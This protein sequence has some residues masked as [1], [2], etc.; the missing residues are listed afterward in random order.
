VPHSV[1]MEW[2]GED[3]GESLLGRILRESGGRAAAELRWEGEAP[4]RCVFTP[5]PGAAGALAASCEG[6]EL[7][8]REEP[9]VSGA[10]LFLTAR[11]RRAGRLERFSVF[12]EIPA[13]RLP[14]FRLHPL[15][16]RVGLDGRDRTLDTGSAPPCEEFA[17]GWILEDG[18][19]G[20]LVMRLPDGSH[21]T[22]FV[23]A[24]IAAGD[25]E[26]V[27]RPGIAGTD[28]SDHRTRSL[29]VRRLEEGA[30]VRFPALRVVP[31]QGG[32]EEG[33]ALFRGTLQ[34]SLARLKEPRRA[35]P[36]SY[37]T[38]HDFGP[39]LSRA[40]LE[41]LL[42][43]LREM[44]FGLLHLDPGWETFWGS[45]VWNR[46]EM[47]PVEEFV[48]LA[49]LHGLKVGC[50]TTLHTRSPEVEGAWY[51]RDALGRKFVAED[52]GEVKLW[53]VCPSGPWRREFVRNMRTLADAGIVFINSDFH[54]WPWQGQ[55]CHDTAHGHGVP[56]T[57]EEWALAV[58]R[59]FEEIRAGHP[60]LVIEMHD[61]V[62]SGEY[63]T[64]AWYL[65]ERPESY[66][67][68][69]AYEFMWK[70]HRD[71]MEGRLFSLYHLRK[72]EPVPL[73]LHMNMS[74]DN[75]NALAF[76]YVASCVTHVGV[77]GVL[78]APEEVREG[79]RRAIATYN[80]FFDEFTRGEFIGIDEL[81]HLHIHPDGGRGVLVC[82][83]LSRE[84][85]RRTVPLP[86]PAGTGRVSLEG[87][88]TLEID[89]GAARVDVETGPEDVT[90]RGVVFG[91]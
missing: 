29:F 19:R 40:K 53:G 47:G 58:N 62:E 11:S 26:R 76:W 54:D 81:T 55:S 61:H 72:A 74:T 52:F 18:R 2:Q 24:E 39:S 84:T 6:L 5:G 4:Q 67:E 8:L 33:V 1:L 43:L 21:E 16:F 90:V 3:G 45:S 17:E 78:K 14:G 66:D 60:G 48:R 68:K 82:F 41:P 70:T 28:G 75:P 13:S 44:G 69:W 64:P 31:F 23:P 77:G 49:E 83:N 88:E 25:G 20:L 36:V 22:C 46:A 38:Y 87:G 9:A 65:F 30:T 15:P 10:D 71:L 79:Y 51:C 35:L 50:W 7:E 86:L 89:G 27:I 63:R 56:L 59:A 80:R 37:N 91:R 12:L 32:W 57:R 73:F 85:V 42:P 34:G